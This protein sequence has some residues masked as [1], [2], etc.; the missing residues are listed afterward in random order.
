VWKRAQKKSPIVCAKVATEDQGQQVSSKDF[1]KLLKEKNKPLRRARRK[2]TMQSSEKKPG[3]RGYLREVLKRQ[4]PPA[5][6]KKDFKRALSKYHL[7]DPTEMR[8]KQRQ[9][10]IQE[11]LY[12]WGTK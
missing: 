5:S 9:Q 8:Q 2:K 6:S 3:L 11:E 12:E 7:L 1:L 4:L 10:R